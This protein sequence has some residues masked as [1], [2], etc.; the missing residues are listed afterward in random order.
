MLASGVFEKFAALLDKDLLLLCA[1]AFVTKPAELA[2][3]RQKMHVPRIVN[4]AI[5][6][7]EFLGRAGRPAIQEIAR[8][9]NHATLACL[10][11]GVDNYD[12]VSLFGHFPTCCAH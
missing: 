3:T 10:R 7:S 2:I 4:F 11:V 6:S 5:R 9:K 12:V 1:S 8:S